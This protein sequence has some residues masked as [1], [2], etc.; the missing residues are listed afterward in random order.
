M[1][2]IFDTETTG[3]PDNF[4]APITDLDNWP[5]VIQLAWQLHD[6][7]GKLIE[8]K[9][10]I[11]KPDG[12]NIPYSSEQIHGI[13]TELA[14]KEGKD[15]KEVLEIFNKSLE[16]AEFVVGH[17]INF[18][19]NVTG[20]EYLRVGMETSLLEKKKLNTATEKTAQLCQLPGGRGGKY[21]IPKLGELYRYLFGEDFVEAHNATADVEATARIFLELIRRGVFT[22]EEL[23]KPAGYL[24]KFQEINP[25]VIPLIGLS[26]KSFKKW[27]AQLK[28]QEQQTGGGIEE[29][30]E[31]ENLQEVAFS[32]LHNHTQ[33]SRLQSTTRI[34]E[35]VK[36]TIEYGMPAV[37]IT[38]DDNMM[39]AFH[40]VEEV[41]AHNKTVSEDKKIKPIVGVELHVVEDHTDKSKKD[42]GFPT[43]FLAKNKKGYQNLIKLS[44]IAQ[45]E[46]FYYN[47]RI[48]KETIQ[49]YKDN[50]IVLSGNLDGEISK[51]I[52]TLGDK[53]A[54]EA[55]K[56]WK[57]E[58]GEDYYIELMRHGLEEEEH[59]NRVLLDFAKKYNIKIVA[60]NNT[61]YLDKEDADAQD[62]L[63]CIRD[64]EKKSTPIGRGRGFRFGLPNNE[65]YF[66]S[67]QEMKDLFKDLPEAIINTNEIIDKI[68]IYSLRNDI[69]LPKFDIPD[70]FK[71]PRDEE[72]GGKR[73]ENAYLRYL[74]YE[75]AKKRWGEITPE[76][77]ERLDFELAT[78]E[79]TGYPGYF[80]I[81]QDIIREAKKMGV[82]VGPGRGSA[83][84]S[85]VAY[86][87]EITNVDPI[88]YQLLF[89][90]FLN[91]ERVSMP[92]IDMDF[93]DEGREKV[94]EYVINKYGKNK[95]AQITTYGT[96]AAKS[97]IRDAA[98]T[99]EFSLEE[100]NK[101][102]KKAHVSLELILKN[103]EQK[104]KDK[105]KRQELAVEAMELAEIAHGNDQAARTI[106]TAGKLEGSLRNLGLHA[107]GFIIAPTDLDNVVP[108]RKAG[109][110]DMYVT[111]FDNSVVESAGL[112]K[113]DF[114]GIKTLTIIRDALRMIKQRTGKEIDIDNVELD[115]KKT[116]QLFQQGRTVTVFQ[117][118]SDGMRKH[119]M[120]LRPTE[121]EDLIAM[122]ALYRPGP[123]EKIPSY[124]RRKHGL[125]KVQYDLPEMEEILRNTYGITVYQEQVMLLSQKLA[126]FSRGQADNLRKAMGKKKHD[127]LA[128]MKPKFIEGGTKNGHPKEILEKIWED[129]KSFASYAFNRSHA[130]SYAIV[131]YQTAYLKA[132]F[133]SEYM[134]AVLSHNLTDA[135]K[136][137]FLMMETR[138][139]GIE[140][141]PPDINESNYLYTVN[142]QGNIRYGLGGAAN[143]GS[144][145]VQAIIEEREENGPYKSFFDFIKRVDLRRVN[146]RTIESLIKAG[147]FDC[148]EGTHRAQYLQTDSKGSSFLEKAIKFGND[149]K[150]NEASMQTSLFGNSQE[151]QIP[152]PDIPQCEPWTDL[153]KLEKEKEV[154]GLYLSGHPLD[155]FKAQYKYYVQQSIY[156]VNK[157]LRTLKGENQKELQ[158]GEELI[159]TE[160][161]KTAKE[162][163]YKRFESLLNREI[164]IG[165]MVT[166]TR[167]F[168]FNTGSKK[169]VLTLED[170]T[171]SIDLELWNEDYLKFKH[172]FV[173]KTFLLIKIRIYKPHWN[174]EQ[175]RIKIQEI[176]M[177]NEAF[178]KNPKDL[179]IQFPARLL[180]RELAD[181]LEITLKKNTG[182]QKMFVHIIDHENPDLNVKLKR[183]EGIKLTP[184]FIKDLEKLKLKFKLQ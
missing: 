48:G 75:G 2:L 51:K 130:V 171:D 46:G 129:W 61:Y 82:M 41:L 165:G 52:L 179:L 34:K 58:F 155:T 20:A 83:A 164:Y 133:P 7:Y 79:E 120:A 85:A 35:L 142:K 140:V 177:L 66:K 60:T 113:M 180:N 115:D 57:Q 143:V 89:E 77:K 72:D 12:F 119:L 90:R 59:V 107:C 26:H 43:V 128:Q 95:V 102:A 109:D 67:P 163:E 166:G 103:D 4:N 64:N 15:L 138:R 47:P 86:C 50:L 172:F 105:V 40:F 39:G 91:P 131:A 23:D 108:I 32:H 93:D 97:A 170:Y 27:S 152:E 153:E 54:E 181:Q 16:K 13:S 5:R 19:L 87:L 92:D 29:K 45:T 121:F 127:L 124:I 71:D 65:F 111:Q 37:A 160:E 161:E 36:K 184:E 116:Y 9:D 176:Q 49:K 28:K 80:L 173:P 101:L 126:G 98:R 175:I 156:T 55:L 81:V 33:Y 25:N 6:E 22:E 63:L 118:E 168:V 76:I 157:M 123:M 139:M 135:S 44:S 11:I 132:N 78:I 145:A 10:F 149:F 42:T 88:K 158:D 62:I 30:D 56:W 169:G 178:E 117:F 68:E 167:E 146:K 94:I 125:E 99:M 74:T 31:Q 122:V 183:K 96:M 154:T 137:A 141:L 106:Q 14:L 69:L 182:K 136:L 147:A 3:L 174:P 53:Q 84:G 110:S 18:D 100:T 8:Q 159:E 148:F 150:K 112:L 162:E 73:G 114:L 1:Y 21:K 151:V 24:Q 134:A 70:E 144:K 104:I 17:N 38:D